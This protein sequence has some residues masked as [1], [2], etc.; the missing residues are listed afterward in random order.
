MKRWLRKVDT[1]TGI[2]IEDTFDVEL[3]EDSTQDAQYSYIEELIPNGMYAVPNVSPKWTGTEWVATAEPPE[4][5]PQQPTEME[6]LEAKINA[7]NEYTDFL[8][9]V[10][11]EM[12]QVVYE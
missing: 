10:I 7:A 1:D 5:Q 8:E 3:L 12:S 4:P 11:V 6:M 2:W 9:E